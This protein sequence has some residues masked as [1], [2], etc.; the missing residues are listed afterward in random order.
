MKKQLGDNWKDEPDFVIKRSNF[1]R[2]QDPIKIGDDFSKKNTDFPNSISHFGF[3]M[4]G[5]DKFHLN[6]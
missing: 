6:L 3:G 4:G 5:N 2:A 1:K